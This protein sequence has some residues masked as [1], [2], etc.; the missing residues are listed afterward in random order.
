V[1][2]SREDVPGTEGKRR[3]NTV[4]QKILFGKRLLKRPRCTG[5]DNIKRDLTEIRHMDVN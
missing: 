1:I 4:F 5:N 2:K 3:A